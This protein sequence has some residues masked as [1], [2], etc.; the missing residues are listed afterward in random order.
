[1]DLRQLRYFLAVVEHGSFTRAARATGRSQQALSKGIQALELQL[2]ARLFDR[3][4]RQATPTAAGRLLLEHARTASDAV[5]MFEQRLAELQSGSEGQVR[6]GTGPT[7]AG[8]LVAPAVL[9][10]RQRWPGIGI[11]VVG[12]ILPELLPALLSRELDVVVTLDTLAQDDPRFACEVLAHDRYV[13]VASANHPLARRRELAPADLLAHPWVSGHR[14][15]A[16]EAELRERFSEAGLAP[17]GKA[18][19]SS[20]PELLRELVRSGGFLSL[21]PRRLAHAELASGQWVAL[22]VPGFAWERPVVVHTRA[23]EPHAAP[24]LRL[25]QA[26]ANA[27]KAI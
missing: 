6:I 9:E 3:G 25:L 7:A 13:V 18:L 8:T 12:G 11:R 23:G 14:L 5:R 4:A 21:V 19:E 1:M 15:G 26:L 20:S 27:A 17:P 22:D 10:L 24:V 16:V 2:G